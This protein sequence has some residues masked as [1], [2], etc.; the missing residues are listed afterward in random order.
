M[1]INLVRKLLNWYLIA[2]HLKGIDAQCSMMLQIMNYFGQCSLQKYFVF[3]RKNICGWRRLMYVD[4][5]QLGSKL[6]GTVG[7]T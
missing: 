2:F 1:C 3:L 6:M 4:N 7:P 5:G